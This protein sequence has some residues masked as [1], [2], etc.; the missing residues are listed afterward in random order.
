MVKEVE[1]GNASVEERCEADER[2]QQEYSFKKLR[3]NNVYK[4]ILF[5][6]PCHT[7]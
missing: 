3:K 1:E 2:K 7:K 5:S 4:P 6:T